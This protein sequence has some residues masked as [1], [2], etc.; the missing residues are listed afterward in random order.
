MDPGDEPGPGPAILGAMSADAELSYQVVL[1]AFEPP[2]LDA[3]GRTP[4][5]RLQRVLQTDPVRAQRLVEHIPALLKR[6]ASLDVA[7]RYREAL[8]A[9]GARVEI[10]DA[11]GQAVLASTEL[12]DPPTL[13]GSEP[14]A[15][16]GAGSD[17]GGLGLEPSRLRTDPLARVAAAV[18]SS[19]PP[20]ASGDALAAE[21]AAELSRLAP[22]TTPADPPVFDGQ[23]PAV[24]APGSVLSSPEVGLAQ[25][26]EPEGWAQALSSPIS[27]PAPPAGPDEA[28]TFAGPGHWDDELPTR[29]ADDVRLPP[30]STPLLQLAG[31][32]IPIDEDDDAPL[33]LEPIAVGDPGLDVEPPRPAS[34]FGGLPAGFSAGRPA[35]VAPAPAAAAASPDWLLSTSEPVLPV[36]DDDPFAVVDDP[37]AA[38]GVR[39][40][41]PAQARHA[42]TAPSP[43]RMVCPRCGRSQLV[44]PACFACGVVYEKLG[45][46]APAPPGPP[47]APPARAGPPSFAPIAFEPEPE[48]ADAF[49]DEDPFAGL[50]EPSRSVGAPSPVAAAPPTDVVRPAAGRDRHAV[51]AAIGAAERAADALV[52]P[53][54][55]GPAGYGAPGLDASAAAFAR[56]P[57]PPIVTGI[58]LDLGAEG[59]RGLIGSAPP[60]PP[61]GSAARVLDLGDDA[62]SG[63]ELDGPA[64][65]P[66]RGF[67]PAPPVPGADPRVA[68]GRRRPAVLDRD[69]SARP[70]PPRPDVLGAARPGSFWAGVLPAFVAPFAGPGVVWV[71][72]MVATLVI[73]GWIPL[74]VF[75]MGFRF[76]YLG[77]LANFFARSVAVGLE[78][79]TRAP[80]PPSTANVKADFVWPG[81]AVAVLCLVL[82][83]FPTYW[84]VKAVGEVAVG[85]AAALTGS[86]EVVRFDPFDPEELFKDDAGDLI[87]IGWDDPPRVVTRAN[88]SRVRVDPEEGLVAVLRAPDAAEAAPAADRAGLSR[89]TVLGLVLAFL[90]PLFYWPAAL[91]VAGLGGD[92][93]RM[94]NP[95]LV[96]QGAVGGGLAYLVVVAIGAGLALL[97]ATLA[98]LAIAAS[99]DEPWLLL[100][101]LGAFVFGFLGY[102]AGVQGHLMGRL[103]AERPAAFARFHQ[104]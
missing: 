94:F 97:G 1:V 75:R 84:S 36:L 2:G 88:G 37:V 31:A 39:H 93:W 40:T 78:G 83:S 62:S 32:P 53:A 90:L 25:P 63:L 52:D 45:G 51:D 43:E 15:P 19:A 50:L 38:S 13:L 16:A 80:D 12:A 21:L 20:A 76:A 22:P 17:R 77:L 85:A 7:L 56:P 101:G 104:E 74:F 54:G 35:P 42:T 27:R 10:L 24:W 44:A 89:S 71:P 61:L 69:P 87:R 5:D 18:R 14:S 79:E 49:G 3:L 23:G 65:P 92:A 41:R 100:D 48:P 103:I 60:A 86:A 72:I 82:F 102:A 98:S 73:G 11:N 70:Q 59:L 33:E 64:R 57:A 9:V 4:G 96:L 30:P 99:F 58:P 29:I 68:A 8:A 81:A 95:I 6:Q 46:P 91:T 26:T 34:M 66:P 47:S 55:A 67:E 28:L